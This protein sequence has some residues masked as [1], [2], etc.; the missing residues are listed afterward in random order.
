MSQEQKT[1]RR[2]VIANNKAWASSTAVRLAWLRQF[3]ARKSA[4]KDAPQWIA[5]V[6]AGAG[7]D[8]RRAME[9]GHQLAW[10]LLGHTDTDTDTDTDSDGGGGGGGGRWHRGQSHP[11]A[12]AALAASPARATVLS[13]AVLLAALEAGT[14][15]NTWRRH[16]AESV[17][18]LRALAGWGYDLSDVEQLAITNHHAHTSYPNDHDGDHQDGD[19]H[20]EDRHDSDGQDTRVNPARDADPGQ[21]AGGP[22]GDSRGD[23][24]GDPGGETAKASAA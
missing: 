2:Q 1:E 8:I 7:H 19:R 13:L 21:R 10:D 6:L 5:A 9:T 3:L 14:G 17:D 12:V 4:P 11:I 24:G 16:T 20:D 22:D 23:A 18:Y 15:T